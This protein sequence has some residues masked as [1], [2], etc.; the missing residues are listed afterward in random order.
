MN[1]KYLTDLIKEEVRD[2]A[3]CSRLHFSKLS[4]T[5]KSEAKKAR[6][7]A[8]R[9]NKLAIV[10]GVLADL[11]GINGNMTIDDLANRATEGSE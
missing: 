11:E 4:S 6:L 2:Y 1:P 8:S 9:K 7:E 10:F 5:L 3:D